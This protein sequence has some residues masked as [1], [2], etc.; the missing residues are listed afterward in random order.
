MAKRWAGLEWPKNWHQLSHHITSRR[1][2]MIRIKNKRITVKFLLNLKDTFLLSGFFW[3]TYHDAIQWEGVTLQSNSCSAE[4]LKLV[5]M[6]WWLNKGFGCKLI[7]QCTK[8]Q[9]ITGAVDRNQLEGT[10]LTEALWI[11][12]CCSAG[13]SL[14]PLVINYCKQ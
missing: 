5:K 2:L 9:T 10:C 8:K 3:K 14:P 1:P 4:I 6:R 13:E 11:Y 12:S 7:F